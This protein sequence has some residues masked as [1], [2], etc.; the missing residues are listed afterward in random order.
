M[1]SWRVDQSLCSGKESL[2]KEGKW[3]CSFLSSSCVLWPFSWE[4]QRCCC[5]CCC[6]C[7]WPCVSLL[8]D[9][10][11]TLLARSLALVLPAPSLFLLRRLQVRAKGERE[12][13][14]VSVTAAAAA[15]SAAAV[16][17]ASSVQERASEMRTCMRSAP[18]AAAAAAAAS[19]CVA[20]L[21]PGSAAAAAA[22]APAFRRFLIASVCLWCHTQKMG[23]LLVEY[24]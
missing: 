9:S 20:A 5:C 21:W 8:I 16:L 3:V 2:R 15:A 13:E 14:C 1:L 12:R 10:V 23:V 7:M 24:H 22:A 19:Q 11:C 6:C 18:Y 17:A 4:Q